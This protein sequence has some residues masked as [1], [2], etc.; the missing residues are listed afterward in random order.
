MDD[1]LKKYPGLAAI[2]LFKNERDKGASLQKKQDR[3]ISK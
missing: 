3:C 1:K 2:K